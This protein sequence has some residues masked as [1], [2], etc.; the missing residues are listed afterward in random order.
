MTGR[1]QRNF[2]QFPSLRALRARSAV[3]SLQERRFAVRLRARACSFLLISNSR[4]RDPELVFHSGAV[5]EARLLPACRITRI[6]SPSHSHCRVADAVLAG[7]DAASGAADEPST[8]D[9]EIVPISA[10]VYRPLPGDAAAC[11]NRECFA[12][13]TAGVVFQLQRRGAFAAIARGELDLFEFS[14]DIALQTNR[15]MAQL[16]HPNY[17]SRRATL[18]MPRI[19]P[20]PGI[21]CH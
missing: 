19:P 7:L 21:K 14:A 2:E 15:E 4:V 3:F 18:K 5:I 16:R 9:S 11:G 1:L 13:L 6:G 10:L 20:F 8:A 12:C 17:V